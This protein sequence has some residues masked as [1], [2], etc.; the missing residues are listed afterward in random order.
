MYDFLDKHKRAVQVVLALVMLPF[1][2]F[3]VDWYFRSGGQDQPVATVGGQKITR[4]EFDQALRDQGERLR[5][6]M[7]RNYDAAMLDN[8]EVR[9]A[10]VENL[11]NQR[12]LA[13]EASRER[14][15]VSDAQLSEVIAGIPV[16]QEDGKF[17]PERYRV[18]L[19]GQNMTPGMFEER[20]RR[21]LALAPLQEPITTGSI[22]SGA[23][24]ARY[25][26]LVEQRRE[27]ASAAID[28]EA[29]AKGVK[30]DDAEVKAFYDQNANAFTI[31]EQARFEYVV[32]S[33][34]AIGGRIVVDPADVRKQY[35]ANL[36]SYSTPEERSASHILIAV[37][38]DASD[39]DKAAAEKKAAAIAAQVRANPASFAGVAKAESQ[40]PGSAREGGALGSFGRGSMVKPFE[41]A[42]FAAK[43]GDIVGPVRT[44]FGWHVIRV[45]GVKPATQRP[46]DEVKGQIEA[47]LKRARAQEKFQAAADQFQNLVYEQADS[48]AGVA[49]ALDLAVQTTPAPVTRAQAQQIGSNSA[50]FAEALFS[51]ASLQAKRN[52]EAIEVAPNT[53][54]AGRILEY[55]PSA[56]RPFDDVKAEIRRQL[57]R[58]AASA[59]A[60]R[61]GRE[62]LAL[63]ERGKSDKEAGLAFGAPVE[64]QRM[65]ASAAFPP[66]ILAKAFQ[67]DPSKL[68]AYFSGVNP[69]GGYSI[70]RLTRVIDA[71][72]L[73]EGRLKLAGDRMAEQ[74]GREFLNA[75]LASLRARADVTIDQVLIEGKTP[76]REGGAAPAPAR[77]APGGRGRPF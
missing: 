42:V 32:L 39:A 71:P 60:E 59:E 35:E 63:L 15:R 22:V 13:A 61:V 26:A 2:F 47:E 21:D 31:P 9:Y 6:S 33:T 30:V 44:D 43:A 75:Y 66:D 52:T 76:D 50:K 19:Q 7:G 27:L 53:L 70:Y 36:A 74:L 55:K 64:L 54:I 51:P 73:D 23:S 3:G 14:F 56:P 5:Q 20:L 65:Q 10:V 38:P 57:E 25:L 40:D 37:R 8:P 48:L 4:Q 69:R 17:S 28:A 34:D 68:P 41:D 16:F 11:V 46:F 77:Q 24:A 29:F 67:A 18:V 1:A 62:K 12:L 49:K 45:T 72:S 58:R